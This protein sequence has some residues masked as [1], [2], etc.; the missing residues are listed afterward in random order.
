MSLES[1]KVPPPGSQPAYHVGYRCCLR[2]RA[3]CWHQE[4]G[5]AR[6][7]SRVAREGQPK[8]GGGKGLGGLLALVSG[9]AQIL[10][11]LGLHALSGGRRGRAAS[12]PHLFLS[13]STSA[14]RRVRQGRVERV[15]APSGLTLALAGPGHRKGEAQDL[16]DTSQAPETHFVRGAPEGTTNLV[17]GSGGPLGLGG[18]PKTL[19]TYPLQKKTAYKG[20]FSVSK[21]RWHE[22]D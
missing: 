11:L 8:P 3:A 22:T 19:P 4:T 13:C 6:Q 16:E 9:M 15:E 7:P 2:G 5:V 12:L 20:Q 18:L 17:Q 10:P 21:Q 1:A 14:L